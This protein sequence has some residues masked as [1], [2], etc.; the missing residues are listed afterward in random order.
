MKSNSIECPI[1]TNKVSI[2]AKVSIAPY[3]S[4]KQN[5]IAHHCSKL[6]LLICITPFCERKTLLIIK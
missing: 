2:F 3:P 1:K 6:M 5:L 4:Q